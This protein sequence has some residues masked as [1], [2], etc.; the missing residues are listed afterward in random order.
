MTLLFPQTSR[1]F[2]VQQVCN[3]KQDVKSKIITFEVGIPTREENLLW[4]WSRLTSWSV[5]TLEVCKNGDCHA[6]DPCCEGEKW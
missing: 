4:Q 3:V 6:I 1:N 5:V 2:S